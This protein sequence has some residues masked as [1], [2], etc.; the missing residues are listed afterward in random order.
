V[1]D[2]WKLTSDAV[3]VVSSVSGAASAVA[4]PEDADA[5]EEIAKKSASAASATAKWLCPLEVQCRGTPR[6]R[7][8]KERGRGDATISAVHTFFDAEGH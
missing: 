3:S 1:G 2:N 4:L 8:G 6:R 5:D 7:D